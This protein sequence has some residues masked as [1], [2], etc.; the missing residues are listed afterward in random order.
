MGYYASSRTAST[1]GALNG[2]ASSVGGGRP[3]TL[4]HLSG[5]RWPCRGLRRVRAPFQS[6]LDEL[7]RVV[8]VQAEAALDRNLF[9]LVKSRAQPCDSVYTGAFWRYRATSVGPGDSVYKR[10]SFRRFRACSV[11]AGVAQKLASHSSSYLM[12]RREG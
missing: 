2:A 12:H 7:A 10:G 9:F 11:G 4:D 6:R 8:P 1:T 5:R 3:L